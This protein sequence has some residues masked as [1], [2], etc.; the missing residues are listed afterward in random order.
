[1]SVCVVWGQQEGT[2]RRLPGILGPSGRQQ[3]RVLTTHPAQA[4]SQEGGRQTNR[5]KDRGVEVSTAE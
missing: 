1:M 2:G 3:P 4:M 5:Q